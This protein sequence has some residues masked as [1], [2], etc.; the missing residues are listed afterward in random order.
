MH[1]QGG[2]IGHGTGADP[3]EGNEEWMDVD[4]PGDINLNLGDADEEDDE[5][6]S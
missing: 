3:K 4:D 6:K 2:G 1:H 5:G